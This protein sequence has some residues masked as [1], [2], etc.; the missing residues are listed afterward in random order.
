GGADPP[1]P[2]ARRTRAVVGLAGLRFVADRALGGKPQAGRARRRR[3]ACARESLDGAGLEREGSRGVVDEDLPRE[4]L[5]ELTLEARLEAGEDV[6]EARPA[7]V[8][9]HHRRTPGVAA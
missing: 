6:V 9:T 2:S 1:L 3:Q 8:R 5:A 7:A 4:L